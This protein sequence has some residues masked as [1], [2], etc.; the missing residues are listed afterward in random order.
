M[1]QQNAVDS[2]EIKAAEVIIATMQLKPGIIHNTTISALADAFLP[3]TP[4]SGDILRPL[5]APQTKRTL[6]RFYAHT[7]GQGYDVVP[8]P[9]S[10]APIVIPPPNH[11]SIYTQLARFYTRTMESC[12][13]FL[14]AT[15]PDTKS[16]YV[17][18]P[19]PPNPF[20]SVDWDRGYLYLCD[21]LRERGVVLHKGYAHPVGLPDH[22]TVPDVVSLPHLAPIGY[23]ALSSIPHGPNRRVFAFVSGKMSKRNWWSWIAVG[24][25]GRIYELPAGGRIIRF[26]TLEEAAEMI[27]QGKPGVLGWQRHFMRQK[28]QLKKRRASSQ[29]ERQPEMPRKGSRSPTTQPTTTNPQAGGI[30][31]D[32]TAPLEEDAPREKKRR[33]TEMVHTGLYSHNS[34][35]AEKCDT[36]S[37][38][39]HQPQ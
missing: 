37:A 23:W 14:K 16:S 17:I 12:D 9:M 34:A 28:L 3:I 11:S 7:P 8:P 2:V 33:K 38:K 24:G 1:E 35:P 20:P 25:D 4:H 27:A 5:D 6:F 13:A 21:R 31:P 22:P 29:D 30:A 10:P 18:V 26:N 15:D 32:K 19:F 36:T 39:N